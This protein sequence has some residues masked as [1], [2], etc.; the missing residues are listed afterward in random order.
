MVKPVG[1][2]VKAPAVKAKATARGKATAKGK[3]KPKQPS[4]AVLK[5]IEKVK[6]ELPDRIKKRTESNLLKAELNEANNRARYA[7]ELDRL[8]GE[9]G[10]YSGAVSRDVQQRVTALA[11]AVRAPPGASGSAFYP[12]GYPAVV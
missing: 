12:R 4:A 7:S 6:L 11:G 10:L 3:A 8:R 2:T 5:R 9:S 1:K